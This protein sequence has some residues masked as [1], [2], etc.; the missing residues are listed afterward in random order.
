ME[1]NDLRA[2]ITVLSLVSF[3]GIVI[4]AY[5]PSRG[6]TFKRAADSI[7]EEEEAGDRQ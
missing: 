6:A 5:T 2:L 7:L 3:L 4:W 1:L